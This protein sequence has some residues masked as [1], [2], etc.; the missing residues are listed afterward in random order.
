[1]IFALKRDVI[2]ANGVP[3]TVG[4]AIPAPGTLQLRPDRR[5]RPLVLR[6]REGDC[7]T[8]HLENLLTPTAN[9]FN[10]IPS[11]VPPFNAPIDEIR[12]MRPNP[13]AR[14]VDRK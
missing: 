6:V 5:P 3:L 7:L 12:M 4:G 9:P 13:V 10:T 11:A 14:N 1:M 2:D 8:V